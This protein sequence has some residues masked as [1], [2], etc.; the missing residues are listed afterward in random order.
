MAEQKP[1][2]PEPGQNKDHIGATHTPKATTVEVAG[3]HVSHPMRELWPGITKLDLIGYWQ[4]VAD[5]ALPGIARRPLAI[6][7]C[8]DGI[9]GESFFQKNRHGFMPDAIRDGM[10]LHQP[11]LAIDDVAGLVAL[12]QMST[13]E[14]HTWGVSEDD[15]A[16]P[17]RMVFDLDPGEG[18]AWS[19]V[20]KAATDIRD[21]LER[22]GLAAFC[23]TSGG[24]GLHVVA[25]LAGRNDWPSVRAFCRTV[26]ETLSA[27][28]P[29]RFLAHT[30]IADRRGRILIDWLRNG[31]GATAIASFAPRARPGATVAT[32]VAWPE[33]TPR[34]DP[35]RF[36]IGSIP[37]R[38]AKLKADPWEGFTSARQSL[39]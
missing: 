16:H 31:P 7:R 34:L 25:P 18:V 38:L 3:I 28:E 39:P 19:D 12:V 23:R 32:P 15:V 27:E 11:Y 33:V 24:K 35:A 37:A 36:T 22:L 9:A 17:D 1:D 4:R 20:I 10:A 2:V 5:V 13:I 26:A 21:R 30:K 14:L 29:K 8:P 6:L